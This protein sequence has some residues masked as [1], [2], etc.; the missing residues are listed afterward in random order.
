MEKY[1]V[2]E[3]LKCFEIVS[4]QITQKCKGKQKANKQRGKSVKSV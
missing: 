4:W 2:E 1:H 3:D